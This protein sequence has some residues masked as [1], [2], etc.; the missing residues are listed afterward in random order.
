MK[1]NKQLL[2]E[3]VEWKAPVSLHRAL[4][5][6]VADDIVS[7]LPVYS[8]VSNQTSNML[9]LTQTQVREHLDPHTFLIG[10]NNESRKN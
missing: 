7:K 10:Q 2:K 3:F 5:A 1:N 8:R 6:C 9:L 4:H